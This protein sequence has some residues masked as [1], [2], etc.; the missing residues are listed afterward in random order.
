[1]SE[2]DIM[3]QIAKTTFNIVKRYSVSANLF[4]ALDATK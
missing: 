4:D 2:K 1:M 3:N